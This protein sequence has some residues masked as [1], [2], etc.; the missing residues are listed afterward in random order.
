MCTTG[1]P[2]LTASAREIL[3][4]LG[5][6]NVNYKL[7]KRDFQEYGG[8]FKMPDYNDK[9]VHY[10]H[11]MQKY[12]IPLLGEYAELGNDELEDRIISA[13]GKVNHF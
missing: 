4:E 1:P 12:N 13:D 11:T 2:V 9:G 8:V 6:K 7:F 10:M 3:L 5:E